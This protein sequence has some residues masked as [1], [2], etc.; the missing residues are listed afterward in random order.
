MKQLEELLNEH[1][2][3]YFVFHCLE[4]FTFFTLYYMFIFTIALFN[5]VAYLKEQ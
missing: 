4:L 3:I 1:L 5:I 2:N